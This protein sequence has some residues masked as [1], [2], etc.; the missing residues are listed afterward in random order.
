MSTT[1]SHPLS[2]CIHTI[3]IL[4]NKIRYDTDI[5]GIK[6]DNKIIK[7]S[8]LADYVTLILQDLK[9]IE[10]A[11]KLLNKF[12]LCS[13]L[14]INI[15]KTKSIYLGKPITADHY[16]HG[17]YWL[18]TP[19]ETRRIYIT[20]NHEDNLNYNYKPKIARLRNLLNIWKQRKLS[21]KGKTTIVA[22][23]PLIYTSSMMETPPEAL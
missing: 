12:S 1:W 3:E 10:Y 23:S 21:I 9:S 15:E 8:L 7:I 16:P 19:L 4:T 22:L 11:L 20:N 6:N 13:G 14:I 17:L 2:R 18:K 5:T